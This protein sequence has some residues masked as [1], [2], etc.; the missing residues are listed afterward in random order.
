[1]EKKRQEWEIIKTTTP[2]MMFFSSSTTK[3]AAKTFTEALD[4]LQSYNIR[5][6]AEFNYLH[7]GL[8]KKS[9]DT[10][11]YG[12]RADLLVEIDLEGREKPLTIVIEVQG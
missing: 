7:H 1:M 5:F 9:S 10:T 8:Y 11:E 2:H 12:L 6:L 4:A 3:F